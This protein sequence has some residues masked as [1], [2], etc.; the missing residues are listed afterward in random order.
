MNGELVDRHI[1]G[2]FGRVCPA[3]DGVGGGMQDVLGVGAGQL[4]CEGD[5]ERVVYDGVADLGWSYGR[6]SLRSHLV[7]R[8]ET[9]HGHAQVGPRRHAKGGTHPL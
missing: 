2:G 8:M 9:L 7:V 3:Q 5:V 4:G 6:G 1:I